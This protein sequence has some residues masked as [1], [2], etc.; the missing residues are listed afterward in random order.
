MASPTKKFLVIEG[1]SSNVGFTGKR[2]EG[3]R[4]SESGR[5]FSLP[6]LSWE[7]RLNGCWMR[8]RSST[9]LK[10]ETFGSATWSGNTTSFGWPWGQQK[11]GILF[12]TERKGEVRRRVYIPEG[13]QAG[14]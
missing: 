7:M 10:E 9:R 13:Q 5:L 6:Q 3:I 14:G 1:N 11:W 2:D 8:C 12:L 4:V